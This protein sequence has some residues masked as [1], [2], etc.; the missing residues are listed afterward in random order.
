MEMQAQHGADYYVWTAQGKGFEIRIRLDVIDALLA[1]IMTGFG[2]LPKRGAEVGGLLLGSIESGPVTV[3]RIEDFEPVECAYTRGPSYLLSEEEGKVFETVCAAL[4]SDHSPPGSSLQGRPVGY[5][6]SHTREG[7]SLNQ[8]DIELMDH[9]F[10]DPSNVVL[11]VKPFATKASPAGFFFRESGAFQETTPLE[12]PFRRREL[13]GEEAPEHKPASDWR[14]RGRSARALAP[15]P[16][17]EPLE[18]AAGIESPGHAYAVTTPARSRMGTWMWFPLSFIF[19]LLG[20]ALGYLAALTVG[21]RGAGNAPADY[22]LALAVQKSGENLL[23]RWNAASPLINGA[24]H[25]VLEIRDGGYAT[26]VD[27]DSTSLRN[28]KIIFGNKT[29]AVDFH[30]TVFVNSNLSVSENLAWHQ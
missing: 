19:L 3:V 5:F 7:L 29:D 15:A 10:P 13:T 24:D 6:R 4:R 25:G 2:A 21:P 17:E 30:L 18:E 27:L 28:G 20:V 12:F 9:L 16:Q 11:L 26:T 8:E 23:L 22:A 1:E 14:H